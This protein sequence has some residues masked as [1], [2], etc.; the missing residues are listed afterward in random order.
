V[1]LFAT[2]IGADAA[3]FEPNRPRL[4][5]LTLSLK[6]LPQAWD[7]VRI[8]QLSDFHYDPYFSVAPIR[9]AVEIVERLQPDLIVL[10][11][12]F[13]TDTPA[14]R[15]VVNKK[16]QN[17]DIE[18]CAQLLGRLRCRLGSIAILGNHDVSFGADVVI[19]SLR[20]R[21]I[22][23]LRNSSQAFELNGSRLWFAGVDDV[24]EGNADLEKSLHGIPQDEAV[25]LLAHE[26]D[27]ALQSS[28]LGI[29]LQL[30]GH[31][32]GGQIR[33]PFL[34]APCLPELAHLYPKGFYQV[35]QTQ[36]YTNV[37]LGTITLPLRFDC[38]PEITLITLRSGRRN[39]S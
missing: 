21:G 28:K 32:H 6:R 10:T 27:F 5:Q 19:E 17:A 16:Q 26:P 7:G 36:L 29:D 3:I 18:A 12:D 1:A 24:L 31:S 22:N 34:G 2:G 38:P 20:A 37:G 39:K 30:S 25:V 11:G 23:V 8:V 4:I 9:K 33:I 15:K 35:G 13:I 14:S